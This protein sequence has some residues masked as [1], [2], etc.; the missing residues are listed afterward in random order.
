M[1]DLFGAALLI[2]VLLCMWL[3]GLTTSL[4]GDPGT[5]V[6][7]EHLLCC[8]GGRALL[9]YLLKEQGFFYLLGPDMPVQ[10][11]GFGP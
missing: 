2:S 3:L 7:T 5:P 6:C 4:R 10:G 8:C 9:I 11:V 1:A